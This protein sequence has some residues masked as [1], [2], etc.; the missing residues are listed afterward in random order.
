MDADFKQKLFDRASAAGFSDCEI[1][2]R[3]GRTFE[4]HVFKGEVSDYK[5]SG[6]EGL[7]FRGTYKSKM[8]YAYTER[9]S[10]DVI[11][12]VISNAA[13]NAG[14]IDDPDAGL[15]RETGEYPA[16]AYNEALN[17]IDQERKIETA[18]AM[19]RAALA[20]D[21]RIKSV[22]YC[23]VGTAEDEVKIANTYGLELAHKRN[24]ALAY[25]YPQAE[26]NGKTKLSG[27]LWHG[28]RWEDFSPEALA[29]KAAGRS[30]S[31]LNAEPVKSGRYKIL[32]SNETA[33]G[34][35]KV[36][37]G[38]FFAEAVQK[39]F[40][41]LKDKLGEAMASPVLNIRDD[42]VC[43]KSLGCIPF[44]AEGVAAQNKAVVENGVL[45]TYLYNLKSAA[46]DNALSTGNGFRNGIHGAITTACTNFYIVPSNK[47]NTD[48]LAS[49]GDGLYITEL[50]G[51]HSG[52]N[53]VSGD[54]S[55]SASG[56]QISD[57]KI[58]RPVEQITI[59]GNFF[60]LL[61]DTADVGADLRFGM[62]SRMGTI[63]A[64]SVLI[65]GLEV[66]G[67]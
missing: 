40:S 52:T 42:A 26:A 45:K 13:A 28:A 15:C 10:V 1:Y 46:K 23:V 8:G 64:P 60:G 62:P 21:P 31:Y 65:N 16:N 39:G 35:L 32:L 7:A 41:L 33:A 67:L 51:L 14:I 49:L 47:E 44:D 2:Y 6:F 11:D 43:G 53:A 3:R 57:A 9:M 38:V 27:E 66:S 59:A 63:G 58:K 25:V 50:S 61:R 37:S 34:L 55:L 30:L 56:F 17:D 24:F 19:E 18:L 4:S 12:E 5:N 48:M 54:F 22:P 20:Y 36:Y 29:A